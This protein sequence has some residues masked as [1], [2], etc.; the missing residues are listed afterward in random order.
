MLLVR[1]LQSRLEIKKIL[2]YSRFLQHG[3]YNNT[4]KM[5][6]EESKNKGKL[7]QIDTERNIERLQEV[8]VTIIFF[9]GSNLVRK[10]C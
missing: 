6:L 2:I 4:L 9:N 5:F 8:K 10:K 7:V 3:D 1:L